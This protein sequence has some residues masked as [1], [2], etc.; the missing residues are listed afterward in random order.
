MLMI[1]TVEDLKQWFPVCVV[2]PPGGGGD[3]KKQGDT[4]GGQLQARCSLI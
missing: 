3:A 1:A 4:G 2:L